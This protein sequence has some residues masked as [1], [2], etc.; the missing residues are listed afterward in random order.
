MVRV[1]GKEGALGAGGGW[2]LQHR[3]RRLQNDNEVI[4]SAWKCLLLWRIS[5]LGEA[6]EQEKARKKS[7]VGG[8]GRVFKRF[9]SHVILKYTPAMRSRTCSKLILAT[10]CV[11]LRSR[12]LTIYM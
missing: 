8:R 11:I 5:I 6:F 4:S 2:E 3:H 1:V 9:R 12:V 10:L 7:G